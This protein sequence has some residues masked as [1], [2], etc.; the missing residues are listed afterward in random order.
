MQQLL[1]RKRG[2]ID[3]AELGRPQ[4]VG[5]GRRSRGLS[6]AQ[7]AQAL[8]VTERTYAEFERGKTSQPST[9]FLDN[10][11]TVLRMNERERNVL[12]VYALGYEPP[13]PMDPCAGTNVAPAWQV[14]VDSVSGQPC[15]INDVAWNVLAANDDFK[16]MFPQSE[17]K[18]PELPERNLIR[19]MLLREDAR[20]H[21]LVDWDT[22]WA[23]QVAAQLRTAVA[24]HS[25]NEDLQL[26]DREVSEDPV[27]GP[28][29]R[30]HSLAY[31][32][33]D[34]DARPMRHAGYVPPRRRE[35]RRTRCCER[36]APSQLGT[37]TMCAAQPF[38]SPGARFFLLPFVPHH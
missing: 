34:G 28:I 12:Y 6:Q 20:E 10:V 33:P 1:Q 26:L 37:V 11:A 18:A 36:H 4:R 2:Q 17:G 29:Y 25:E 22:R 24:A 31:I 16:R 38:G 8:F 3:P 32:H 27:A 9:E 7:V 14:A 15:Y 35:D 13:F 19:W 30:D 23:P 21:H 5:R